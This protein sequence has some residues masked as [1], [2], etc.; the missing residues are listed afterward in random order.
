[1]LGD[2]LTSHYQSVIIMIAARPHPESTP[3]RVAHSRVA[4]YKIPEFDLEAVPDPVVSLEKVGEWFLDADARSV[5]FVLGYSR[6]RLIH[7][8]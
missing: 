2:L 4:V 8:P 5:G 6:H 1:M 3:T 7:L